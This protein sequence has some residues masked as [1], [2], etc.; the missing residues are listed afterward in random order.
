METTVLDGQTTSQES[1]GLNPVGKPQPPA[2]AAAAADM[3]S[4]LPD[5]E[6]MK[7]FGLTKKAAM[8]L[9]ANG[10]SKAYLNTRITCKVL[11]IHAANSAE[12]IQMAQKTANKMSKDPAFDG[13][14]R[15]ACL[16]V[17]TQCGM[18]LARLSEV[19]IA[20]ARNLDMPEEE[21]DKPPVKATQN[22]YYGFPPVSDGRER[23]VSEPANNGGSQVTDIPSEVKS[24]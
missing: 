7:A 8:R 6:Q 17:V 5:R 15:A 11:L 4:S 19:A 14:T 24:A 21:G 13:R 9:L 2:D 3:S 23:R 1:A 16:T 18:S 22:N 20:T 12:Q 10:K